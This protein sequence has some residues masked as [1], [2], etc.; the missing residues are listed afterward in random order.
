MGDKMVKN[1]NEIME[2]DKIPEILGQGH[3][4]LSDLVEKCMEIDPKKRFSCAEALQHK[5]FEHK[6]R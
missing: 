6:N 3:Q 5:Y 1:F 2:L 4:E